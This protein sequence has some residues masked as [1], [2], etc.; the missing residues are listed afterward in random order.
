[1]VRAI[2]FVHGKFALPGENRCRF[3]D[4]GNVFQSFLTEL[5]ADFSQCLALGITEL[6][7]SLDLVAQDTVFGHQVFISKEELLID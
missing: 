4:P 7:T 3:D 6:Y 2:E 1:L 5:L